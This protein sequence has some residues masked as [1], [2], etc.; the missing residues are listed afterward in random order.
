MSATLGFS[1]RL[2]PQKINECLAHRKY[3]FHIQETGDVKLKFDGEMKHLCLVQT[4]SGPSHGTDAEWLCG[5]C[6]YEFIVN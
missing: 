6:E 4:F 2:R 5:A 3:C 1:S